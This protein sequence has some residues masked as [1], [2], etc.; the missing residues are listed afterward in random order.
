MDDF[1]SIRGENKLDILKIKKCDLVCV[2]KAQ[3]YVEIFFI[4]GGEPE[5]MLIRTTLKKIQIELNF[6]IKVHRSHLINPSH[7]KAWKNHNTLL[8]T[9][10]E[11]PI[12]KNYKEIISS[13]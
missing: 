1:I 9:Q 12:S 6:L 11:I 10:K 2:S 13:L 4:N 8:L 5:A 3:N 7:F